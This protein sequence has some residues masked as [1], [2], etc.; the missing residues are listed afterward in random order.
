M[1]TANPLPTL[2]SFSAQDMV[3]LLAPIHSSSGCECEV[4]I[5]TLGNVKRTVDARNNVAN[6]QKLN[7]LIRARALG[8]RWM[9]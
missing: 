1:I 2:K 5:D 6:L 4:N 8:I 7:N 9:E 3:V